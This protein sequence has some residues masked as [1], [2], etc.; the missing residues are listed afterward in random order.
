[1]FG[2]KRQREVDSIINTI[3]EN[4]RLQHGDCGILAPPL[5]SDEAMRLLVKYLLGDNWYVA[6]S[7]GQEQVNT[8]IVI[9][10]IQKYYKR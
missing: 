1:M 7:C 6:Y 4:A 9:S 10:I 5:S 2:S 8:E 3:I